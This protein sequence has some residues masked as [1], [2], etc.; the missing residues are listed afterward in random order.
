MDCTPALGD[1]YRIGSVYWDAELEVAYVVTAS[2][3]DRE[4]Q[5]L[6]VCRADLDYSCY[7]RSERGFWWN[8]ETDQVDE[9]LWLTDFI[10]FLD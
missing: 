4:F 8:P 7:G 2:T 1:H 6:R 10:W 9:L 3:W 5:A